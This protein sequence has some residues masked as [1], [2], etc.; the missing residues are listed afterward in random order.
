MQCAIEKPRINKVPETK[1]FL[2]TRI[3]A[4]KELDL[5]CDLINSCSIN[6]FPTL[7]TRP[8]NT[9]FDNRKIKSAIRFKA[10]NINK[11]IRSI[12]K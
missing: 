10:T 11:V 2:K 1:Y 5:N 9:S 7:A 12:L 6:D 8:R 4:P 3:K